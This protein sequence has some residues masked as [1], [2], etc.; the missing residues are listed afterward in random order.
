MRIVGSLRT[1][2]EKQEAGAEP[3]SL[4]F[5]SGPLPRPLASRGNPWFEH[6]GTPRSCASGAASWSGGSEGS[7]RGWPPAGLSPAPA[8]D[9]GGLRARGLEGVPLFF[10]VVRFVVVPVALPE[11][12]LVAVQELEASEPLRALPEVARRDDQAQRPAVLG[13]ERFAVGFI[14]EKS[15][16]Q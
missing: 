2:F 12:G 4:H 9:G 1:A 8:A 10:P 16:L 13:L 6:G 11:A 7:F 14:R 15:V 5:A 3:A